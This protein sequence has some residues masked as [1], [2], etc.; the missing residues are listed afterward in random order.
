MAVQMGVGG[1]GDGICERGVKGARAAR[2]RRQRS[3]FICLAAAVVSRCVCVCVCVILIDYL[4]F[5]HH[6]RCVCA[7]QGE[8]I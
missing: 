7:G 6:Y 8:C 2:S 1:G 4:N 3:T 5:I